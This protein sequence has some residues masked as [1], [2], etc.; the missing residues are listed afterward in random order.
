MRIA[1][2]QDQL[3][4]LTGFSE[5]DITHLLEDV[6]TAAEQVL[7]EHG[8]ADVQVV[9]DDNL[10]RRQAR[11]YDPATYDP[12]GDPVDALTDLWD[13]IIVRAAEEVT[14]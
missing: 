6:R 1:I 3:G 7:K 9:V 4:D 11:P 13:S 14:Q 12:D 10:A 8:F 2:S 5:T